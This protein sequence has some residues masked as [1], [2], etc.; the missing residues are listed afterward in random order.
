[1]ALYWP[2]GWK[3]EYHQIWEANLQALRPMFQHLII[4]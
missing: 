3:K 1:M 2:Q 4:S